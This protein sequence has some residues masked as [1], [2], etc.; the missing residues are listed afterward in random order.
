MKV[1]FFL[2]PQCRN[3]QSWTCHHASTPSLAPDTCVFCVTS[4]QRSLKTSMLTCTHIGTGRP[5]SMSTSD[6][7]GSAWSA[8]TSRSW[9]S[10]CLLTCARTRARS[11]TSV[12]C[13]LMPAPR[14]ETLQLTS[15]L[16]TLRLSTLA[17]PPA[18]PGER[19]AAK[20]LC[21]FSENHTPSSCCWCHTW[22]P[23]A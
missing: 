13:V 20:A 1:N 7:I 23:V 9:S 21:G 6:N 16:A 8:A 17:G 2:T 14:V 11:H 18:G 15:D 10:T 19:Q 3:L 12:T 22:V 4:P 5:A